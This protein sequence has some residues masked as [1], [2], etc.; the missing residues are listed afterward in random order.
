M[1]AELGF[2]VA[3]S[4]WSASTGTGTAA[5]RCPPTAIRQALA[6]GDLERANAMLGRPHEVRGLVGHGDDRARELGFR[7]A[8]VAVPD[9]ICLPAD[10][11]Y[12]GWYLRPD[13]VARPAAHLPRAAGPRSTSEPTP[14]CSRPTSS[15]STATSTS[16]PARVRF[17]HGCETS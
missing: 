7:T 10:G 17:V 3:G 2:D 14:R 5:D 16:E 4:T 9:D 11:I 1:G 8:N 12:A 13:G 15:T 6:D